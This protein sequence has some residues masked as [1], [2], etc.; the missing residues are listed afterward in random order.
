[1]SLGIVT[2]IGLAVAAALT[3]FLVRKLSH[4]KLSGL[5]AKRGSSSKIAVEAEFVDGPLHVPV[6]LSLTDRGIIYENPDLDAQL[7]FDHVDEVEYGDT[8]A[9]GQDVDPNCRVLRLRT[10]GHTFE[11]VMSAAD[12][13]R[14]MELLPPHR[15]DEPG[16]VHVADSAGIGTQ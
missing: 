6:A 9:T 15:G 7:D 8:L 3:W 5:V 11:F 1:M 10:R 2:I 13:K 12:S 16:S 4:D 14:W